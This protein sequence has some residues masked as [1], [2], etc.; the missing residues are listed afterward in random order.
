MQTA[1]DAIKF[2]RASEQRYITIILVGNK[3]DLARKR[4]ISREGIN[5]GQHE[6][7]FKTLFY[8]R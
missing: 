8:Y 3:S 5:F 2:L 4:E 7:Y 6:A 1:I